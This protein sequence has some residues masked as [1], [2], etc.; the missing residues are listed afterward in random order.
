MSEHDELLLLF[1]TLDDIDSYGFSTDRIRDALDK[2]KHLEKRMA[3]KDVELTRR[4][5]NAEYERAIFLSQIERLRTWAAAWKNAAKQERDRRKA[6]K[7]TI[8]D[9]A[10]TIARW[11][12]RHAA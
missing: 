8:V 3:R 10:R 2:I 7:N 12:E 4:E 1:D 6:A 11:H 9:I 5:L